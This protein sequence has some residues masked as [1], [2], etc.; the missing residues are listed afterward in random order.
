MNAKEGESEAAADLSPVANSLEENDN[1][2]NSTNNKCSKR[3]VTRRM[4]NV[5]E[6]L[7]DRSYGGHYL[8]LPT[9]RARWAS[10]Y[11]GHGGSC[12][13]SSLAT[14]ARCQPSLLSSVAW[15]VCLSSRR[16]A[17]AVVVFD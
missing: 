6:L 3:S 8:T 14:G 4:S 5:V 13:S 9:S 1:N 2:N 12:G 10:P 17:S 11:S 16:G 15:Y 7:E